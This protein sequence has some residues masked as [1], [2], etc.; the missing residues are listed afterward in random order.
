MDESRLFPRKLYNEPFPKFNQKGTWGVVWLIL[1]ASL[2][3]ADTSNDGEGELEY[4]R[5]ETDC[6]AS[7]SFLTEE[8]KT[9]L[10]SCVL[11]KNDTVFI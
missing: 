11:A 5:T 3:L 10:A 4:F 8:Y 1:T 7:Q 6:E 2:V 9:E